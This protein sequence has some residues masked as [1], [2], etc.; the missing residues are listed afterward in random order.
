MRVATD[1]DV[2]AI[3]RLINIAFVVERPIFDHDRV[4]DIGVRDYMTRG[5]FLLHEDAAGKL[6]ACGGARSAR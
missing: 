1:D 3:T 4:D 5:K 6:I 2:P